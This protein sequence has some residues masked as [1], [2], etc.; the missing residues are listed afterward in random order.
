MDAFVITRRVK[1]TKHL[2]TSSM[3]WKSHLSI[4]NSLSCWL[5]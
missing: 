3:I 4:K 1:R 2:Q 5:D